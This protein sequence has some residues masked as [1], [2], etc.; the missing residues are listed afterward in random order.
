VHDVQRHAAEC[1]V[2]VLDFVGPRDKS[3]AVTAAGQDLAAI[4]EAVDGLIV[5][6]HQKV[7]LPALGMHFD[8]HRLQHAPSLDRDEGANDLVG[9]LKRR[10][11]RKNVRTALP[12]FEPLI[13]LLGGEGYKDIPDI[14]AIKY[15][16]T[17][18]VTQSTLDEVRDGLGLFSFDRIL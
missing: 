14:N 7:D 17:K 16:L 10:Q 8:R 13:T 3:K 2:A 4:H 6:V 15:L 18:S 1:I 9:G 11:S 5:R 12:A